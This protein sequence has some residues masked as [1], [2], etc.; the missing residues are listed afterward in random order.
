MRRR[1]LNPDFF[2][3][4]D[5]VANFDFGG[6][7]L[8]Q[9]LWCLAEDSGCFEPN[10]LLLK[11]KIFP[12]DDIPLGEIQKHIDRL[13]ELDKIVLYQVDGKEYAW[14]KN[15]HK[16]QKLDRPAPPAI[17]LPEWLVFHGEEEYGTQR[18]KWH[19]EVVDC[20]GTCRGHVGDTTTPEEKLIEEKR[21]EGERNIKDSPDFRPDDRQSPQQVS[22]TPQVEPEEPP[23]EEPKH[24]EDSMAF[25]AASYLRGRILTNNPRARVPTQDVEDKLMQNW[26]TELDR[27]HRLGPPGGDQGY[28]WHEV[29]Q[30]ID[31]SQDD[32]FWRA[33]I[34]SAGKLREKCVQ[35]ENQMKRN[36]AKARGHPGGTPTMSRNVANALRLVQKYSQE[37]GDYP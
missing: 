15:F 30:L 27:L 11:M 36:M 33:N 5:M 22:D 37:E 32:E 28:N 19:Y 31:F 10:P 4:P 35:L 3:D 7:L 12:G 1:M 26:A 21:T 6:R 16:H 9:G 13:V 24:T 29:R 23:K 18:H 20:S 17:P 34:L 25:K 2:T 8:Y 14:L